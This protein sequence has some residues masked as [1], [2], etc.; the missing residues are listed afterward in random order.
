MQG[1][2]AV[3]R[4]SWQVVWRRPGAPLR[5][6][7]A[8]VGG[9]GRFV[10]PA[11]AREPQGPQRGPAL[12]TLATLRP[13]GRESGGEACGSGTS[14]P[15]ALGR[16]LLRREFHASARVR[17]E[18]KDADKDNERKRL[19]SDD[20]SQVQPFSWREVTARKQRCHHRRLRAACDF[21]R[22]CRESR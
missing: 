2:S 14:L 5:P 11:P 6:S 16:Q 17:S 4:Q 20:P 19:P 15:L 21:V 9:L 12:A 10:R 8:A 1:L 22:W 18:D 3:V 13:R 7:A